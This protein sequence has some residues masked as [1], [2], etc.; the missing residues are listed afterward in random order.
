MWVVSAALWR[1]EYFCGVEA[2]KGGSLREIF[3]GLGLRRDP[4]VGRVVLASA[5]WVGIL[6]RGGV[7]S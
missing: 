7:E 3:C 2:A 6:G 1:V 4:S 5:Q